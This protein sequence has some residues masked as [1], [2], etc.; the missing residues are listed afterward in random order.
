MLPSLGLYQSILLLK[1]V[2]VLT[3]SAAMGAAF[4][5]SAPEAR[6]R[7]VHGVASPSLLVIWLAGYLLTIQLG[8]SLM[9]L[10]II[11][12]LLLSLISLGALIYSVSIR[13]SRL[14]FCAAVLP[15]VSV[16]ALMVFRPT[17]GALLS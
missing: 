4:F 8:I 1:F 11:G 15:L 12:G 2:S 13:R 16:L 7:A 6:K 9:E 3:Y 17:W 10:W 14:V 5:A